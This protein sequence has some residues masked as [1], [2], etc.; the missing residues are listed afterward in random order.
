MPSQKLHSL[1]S[2]ALLYLLPNGHTAYPRVGCIR[3][4][5]LL[6]TVVFF[7]FGSKEVSSILWYPRI[8]SRSVGIR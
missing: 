3:V 2:V 8:V 7:I 4:F 5:L 6:W 1:L